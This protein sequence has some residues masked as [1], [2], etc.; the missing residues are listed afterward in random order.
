MTRLKYNL[1][2]KFCLCLLFTLSIVISNNV[3]AQN[4]NQPHLTRTNQNLVLNS[5]FTTQNHWQF[6]N[7]GCPNTT[8]QTNIDS[9]DG[10]GYCLQFDQGPNKS[11]PEF[12]DD[13]CNPCTT[14]P[15]CIYKSRDFI[16]ST[17]IDINLTEAQNFTVGFMAKTINTWPSPIISVQISARDIYG[18]SSNIFGS[19]FSIAEH[20]T[21]QECAT[22]F[23]LD[24]TI[25][26]ITIQIYADVIISGQQRTVYV[27]DVYLGEGESFEESPACKEAFESSQVRIDELGNFEVFE[28]NQWYPFFPF[29]MMGGNHRPDWSVYKDAG[30]NTMCRQTTVNTVQKAFDAG[31][32][33]WT[34]SMGFIVDDNQAAINWPLWEERYREILSHSV[35]QDQLLYYYLDNEEG[36]YRWWHSIENAVN[37]IKDLEMEYFGEQ[38]HP[39]YFL[40]GT[41]GI[42]RQYNS[43]YDNNRVKLCDVT[44]TYFP[45]AHNVGLVPNQNHLYGE[46]LRHPSNWFKT[47]QNLDGQ[48]IPVSIAQINSVSNNSMRAVMFSAIANGAK[49]MN[50]WR[51]TYPREANG[52]DTSSDVTAQP[53]WSTFK[54]LTEDVEQMMPLIRQP[55]WTDWTVQHNQAMNIDYGSRTLNGEE[56]LI[57]ANLKDETLSVT[58]TIDDF[59]FTPQNIYDYFSNDLVT[60]WDQNTNSFTVEL[61][62][63][64]TGV[65]NISDAIYAKKIEPQINI[66]IHPNP[67]NNIINVK[68]NSDLKNKVY[69]YQIYNLNGVLVDNKIAYS[70][71]SETKIN[72]S[73]LQS[74]SYIIK[75]LYNNQ[76]LASQKFNVTN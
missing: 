25:D 71:D 50:Y 67:A 34:L 11:N 2:L 6:T 38:R 16:V 64:G 51:D 28:S 5:G 46:D 14:G 36:Q 49:G 30:F 20:N 18:N 22:I 53:W 31:I 68:L 9:Y 58:F 42:S 3:I 54:Q 74:G 45:Q 56:Y 57:V 39:F 33:W 60:T 63:F 1:S 44:G 66:N 10:D 4:C 24:E 21:W 65:Y 69:K 52:Y 8:L 13:N 47:L 19:R 29:G 55:H 72:I 76:P 48:K 35:Y 61:D 15:S 37:W 27:D 75:A 26:N 41:Y 23:K 43:N 59:N 70:A 17:P 40:N 7:N 62:G 32:Y 73:H 12:V